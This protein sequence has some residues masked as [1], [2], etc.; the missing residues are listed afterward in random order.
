MQQTCL[1]MATIDLGR[2]HMPSAH[3]LLLQDV[4]GLLVVNKE[5]QKQACGEDQRMMRR[6]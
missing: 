4:D 3:P 5:H 6:R 1:L 2:R